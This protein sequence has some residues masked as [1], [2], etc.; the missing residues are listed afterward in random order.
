MAALVE[1]RSIDWVMLGIE[2]AVLF[3]ILYEVIIG[4]VRHRGDHA[5]QSLLDER[6][7]EVARLADKGKRLGDSVPDPGINNE[8]IWQ[9]WITSVNE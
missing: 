9:R 8:Q 6:A 4:E 3:L 5:R 2:A 1:T 7:I